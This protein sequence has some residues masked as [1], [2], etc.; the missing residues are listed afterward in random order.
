[1]SGAFPAHEG[2]ATVTQQSPSRTAEGDLM[3]TPSACGRARFGDTLA[4]DGEYLV[5]G[6]TARDSR[7][8]VPAACV[9]EHT[10]WR[11]VAALAND[12]RG[13]YADFATATAVS[14][15]LGVIAVNAPGHEDGDGPVHVFE[16]ARDWQRTRLIANPTDP[17]HDQSYWADSLAFVGDG[18]AIGPV[19]DRDHELA[20]VHVVRATFD[21]APIVVPQPATGYSEFGA[22]LAASNDLLAV[23]APEADKIGRAY[24]FRRAGDRFALVATATAPTPAADAKFGH[25]IALASDKLVVASAGFA[26]RQVTPGQVDTFA[27]RGGAL[28]HLATLRSPQHD[29]G[30]AWSIAF[31]GRRLAVGDPSGPRHRGRVWRYELDGERFR[32]LGAW[33]PRDLV[34]DEFFGAAVALGPGWLAAGAPSINAPQR[35]GRV[36]VHDWP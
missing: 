20:A 17:S 23:G 9:Y 10:S 15:H 24:V 18:L 25:A 6:A 14:A 30:Y 21:R 36:L 7:D 35:F 16:C 5:V 2:A 32:E 3:L 11:I 31:D 33:E 1:M 19:W 29:F 34:D 4:V 22:A 28:V 27:L 13:T 8:G 12:R 26:G